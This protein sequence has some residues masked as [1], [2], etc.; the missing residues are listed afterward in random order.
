MRRFYKTATVAE[1]DGVFAVALD[2]RTIQSP[3]RNRF[4]VP[5]RALA[6]AIADEWRC[7][8]E[9]IDFYLMPLMRLAGIAIDDVSPRLDS[10]IDDII[11]Y[12][13]TDLTCYRADS[14]AD[15]VDRQHHQWQPLLDWIG[16]NHG[17]RFLPTTGVTPV[18][19]PEQSL[20]ALRKAI[21]TTDPFIVAGLNAATKACG[22]VVIAL[23]LRDRR[24][25]AE[26]AW[27]AAQLDENFQ[28]EKWGVD[29]EAAERRASIRA[30]LG[31]AARFLELCT[32]G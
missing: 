30:D 14:P 4:V 19:Q 10:A 32:S 8:D 2:G 24:I 12:G 11:D 5:S 3:A 25:D 15:L 28:I 1:D 6:E 17:V 23:A 20:A 13:H 7:Q 31:T 18:P 16:Q 22:S 29:D 26:T 27:E 21:A 9:E